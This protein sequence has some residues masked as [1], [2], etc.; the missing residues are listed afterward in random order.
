[1]VAFPVETA[2]QKELSS[3]E[4]V[5]EKKKLEAIENAD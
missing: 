2:T 4:M 1:M 3:P 5:T